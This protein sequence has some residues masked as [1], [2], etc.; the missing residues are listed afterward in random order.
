MNLNFIS[1]SSF[2]FAFENM[3]F[4]CVPSPRFA[5]RPKLC[6][7]ILMDRLGNKARKIT[8]LSHY[9]WGQG[10]FEVLFNK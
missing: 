8:L 2:L 9:V 1:N 7:Q 6:Y 4:Y 3:D 10:Q 5:E